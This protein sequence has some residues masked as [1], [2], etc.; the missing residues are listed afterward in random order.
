MSQLITGEITFTNTQTQEIEKG[1]AF[2]RTGRRIS[3]YELCLLLDESD[4]WDTDY[5]VKFNP[6]DSDNSY[7]I[8]SSNPHNITASIN[9]VSFKSYAGEWVEDN[10]RYTFFFTEK[11]S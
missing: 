5:R 4:D 10:I 8:S 6:I 2:I 7:F 3:D 1:R 11:Q 9:R